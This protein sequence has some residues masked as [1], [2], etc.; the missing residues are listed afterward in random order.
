MSSRIVLLYIQ[1]CSYKPT[2]RPNSHLDFHFSDIDSKVMT[3][4]ADVLVAH[5]ALVNS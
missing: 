4:V 1:Y 2:Y 5:L 3:S